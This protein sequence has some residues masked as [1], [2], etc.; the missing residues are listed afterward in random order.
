MVVMP[1][2]VSSGISNSSSLSISIPLSIVAM[3]SEISYVMKEM[4]I[5]MMAMSMSTATRLSIS[6]CNSISL[7]IIS[8]MSISIISMSISLPI[9]MI[10]MIVVS[11]LMPSSIGNSSSLSAGAPLSVV[12]MMSKIANMMEEMVV[13]MVAMSI[14]TPTSFS[15]RLSI[16]HDYAK[17]GE[18]EE[19]HKL[20]ADGVSS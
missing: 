13:F 10:S 1:V 4:G 9:S 14:S 20:H 16:S 8:M 12:T 6:L 7:S 11:V 19:D 2:L 5:F 3:V 15:R 18:G 17:E